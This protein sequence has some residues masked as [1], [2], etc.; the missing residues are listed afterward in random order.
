MSYGGGLKATP[1]LTIHLIIWLLLKDTSQDPPE[2]LWGTPRAP[3]YPIASLLLKAASQGPPGWLWGTPKAPMYLILWL[4]LKDTS[5]GPKV[6][7][8]RCV[9]YGARAMVRAPKEP[10][11]GPST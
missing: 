5:Q 9:R 10:P 6:R 7:A 1:R 8:L 3:M 4:L 2:L 11:G